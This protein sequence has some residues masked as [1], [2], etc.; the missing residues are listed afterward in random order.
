MCLASGKP[1]P[2]EARRIRQRREAEGKAKAGD[3]DSDQHAPRSR[4]QGAPRKSNRSHPV[5]PVATRG[6]SR[7]IFNDT[8]SWDAN[9]RIVQRGSSVNT[10]D[11]TQPQPARSSFL[12]TTDSE[13]WTMNRCRSH[14]PPQPR[15]LPSGAKNGMREK[16]YGSISRSSPQTVDS[17]LLPNIDHVPRVFSKPGYDLLLQVS[18]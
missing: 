17:R 3:Q 12:C 13:L 5:P 6:G 9:P 2:E 15:L 18:L 11:P 14:P 1:S 4:H 7:A 16:R 10:N 8:V